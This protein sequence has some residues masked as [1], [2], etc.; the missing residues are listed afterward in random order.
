M[1]CWLAGCGL[2]VRTEIPDAC[3]SIYVCFKGD[4][5][6]VTTRTRMVHCCLAAVHMHSMEVRSITEAL[7]LPR[8][9]SLLYT[10]TLLSQIVAFTAVPLLNMT[11]PITAAC[12]LLYINSI[13][14]Y[15]C[16]LALSRP[17]LMMS[18]SGVGLFSRCVCGPRRNKQHHQQK[19]K[20]ISHTK[21]RGT[22]AAVFHISRT[23]TVC[24]LLSAETSTPSS[25][26]SADR[27]ICLIHKKL[28]HS[29]LLAYHA[30]MHAS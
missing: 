25:H 10:I 4:N 22:A 3:T 16:R 27:S 17:R 24:L 8:S 23:T 11:I 12:I 30:R 19:I 1:R 29:A 15:R 14:M 13:A 2:D 9:Y 21:A 26:H 6:N 20:H 7:Y 28:L 5:S 18:M